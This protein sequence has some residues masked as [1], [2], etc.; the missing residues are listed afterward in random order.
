MHQILRFKC[1]SSHLAVVFA[2]FIETKSLVEHEDVIGA[3]LTGNAY[4]LLLEI[5]QYP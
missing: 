2:Q 1:F 5:W 3:A 4:I